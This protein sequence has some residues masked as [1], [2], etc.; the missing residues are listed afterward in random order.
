MTTREEFKQQVMDALTPRQVAD[1][2]GVQTTFQ[3]VSVLAQT[4]APQRLAEILSWLSEP[5]R[6]YTLER[7][8]PAM[9]WEAYIFLPSEDRARIVHCPSFNRWEQIYREYHEVREKQV[10]IEFFAAFESDIAYS[11]SWCWSSMNIVQRGV[12]MLQMT[13]EQIDQLQESLK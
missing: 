7:L 4:D 8:E 12:A 1:M 11:I 2:L 5:Y 9:A 3:S 6:M 10:Q 13:D